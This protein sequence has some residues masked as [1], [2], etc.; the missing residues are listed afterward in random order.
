MT[1]YLHWNL[2]FLYIL[3]YRYIQF[4]LCIRKMKKQKKI[5]WKKGIHLVFSEKCNAGLEA[6]RSSTFPKTCDF[7]KLSWE[8][9]LFGIGSWSISSVIKIFTS[10]KHGFRTYRFVQRQS[11]DWLLKMLVL[12]TPKWKERTV[13]TSF[14]PQGVSWNSKQINYCLQQR[15]WTINTAE[16][17]AFWRQLLACQQTLF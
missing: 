16:R 10:R 15:A 11:L 6:S 8:V 1:L 4:S 17:K 7:W 5:L 12:C 13:S 9:Q 3:F 2:N 14:P